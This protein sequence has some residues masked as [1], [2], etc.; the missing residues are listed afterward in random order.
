MPDVWTN[1]VDRVLRELISPAIWNA[2]IAANLRL[3][4][5]HAHTG[6]AGDGAQLSTFLTQ[7]GAGAWY[8]PALTDQVST[9]AFS[10]AN[11]VRWW[12]FYLPL[13]LSISSLTIEV[14]TLQA[15]SSVGFG[16]YNDQGT[17]QYATATASSASTGIKRVAVTPVLLESGFYILAWTNTGAVA[18]GRTSGG[19]L[20]SIIVDTN[21]QLGTAANASAAGVL[22]ATLGALSG[23]ATIPPIIC[24]FEGA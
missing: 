16:I 11:Q 4:G 12:R 22:P 6:A 3:L 21:P 7:T 17:V 8:I 1:P 15:G 18:Q 10:S 20:L 5:V 2:D 9:S 13:R 24:K 19:S 23:S 14:T